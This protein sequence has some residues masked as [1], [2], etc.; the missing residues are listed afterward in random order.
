MELARAP[1]MLMV[2]RRVD[3]VF[4][5]PVWLPAELFLDRRKGCSW[6]HRS[7]IRSPTAPAW[8]AQPNATPASDYVQPG[9]KPP[10]R[11]AENVRW[12]SPAND[13]GVHASP[14]DSRE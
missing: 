7:L 9:G 5:F 1:S 12:E 4:R 3:L 2:G 8:P 11:K 6:P 14:A 13:H 10:P